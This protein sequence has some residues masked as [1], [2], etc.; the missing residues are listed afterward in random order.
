[1]NMMEF[2]EGELSKGY[3]AEQIAAAF[4]GALTQVEHQ[5]AADLARADYV[6]GLIDALDAAL[7]VQVGG[8]ETAAK[9]AALSIARETEWDLETVKRFEADAL[10][11]LNALFELYKMEKEGDPFAATIRKVLA[12]GES[13]KSKEKETAGPIGSR[14][15][16]DTA[17]I[18]E[19]LKSL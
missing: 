19:F 10:S 4:S 15:K 2:I 14:L 18:K 17:A 12:I 7:D 16:D 6:N 13:N 9:A 5:R 3:T 8:F 1:M 11:Q